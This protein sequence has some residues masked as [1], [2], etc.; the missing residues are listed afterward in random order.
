MYC[1]ELM[2]C[3]H[4]VLIPDGYDHRTAPIWNRA[5]ATHLLQAIANGA[6]LF[7]DIFG[8]VHMHLII[9]GR[10]YGIINS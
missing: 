4:K 6:M 9:Q 10:L 7:C 1:A 3:C 5:W 2:D 8:L